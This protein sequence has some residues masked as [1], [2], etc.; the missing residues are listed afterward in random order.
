MTATLWPTCSSRRAMAEPTLPF[1]LER[2]AGIADSL[3]DVDFI[4][5][6]AFGCQPKQPNPLLDPSGFHEEQQRRATL[7]EGFGP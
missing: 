2:D 6:H 5:M 1:F 7:N 4:E 3:R